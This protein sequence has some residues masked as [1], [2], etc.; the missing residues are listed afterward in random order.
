MT[1]APISTHVLDL[2][3]GEPARG[4][5]VRLE[6]AADGGGWRTVAHSRTDADGR[7]RGWVPADAWAAGDY[8]LVFATEAY[9]GPPAFFPEVVVGFRVTDPDVHHH[10]PL[11]LNRHGYTTYRGS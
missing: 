6:R 9:L 11:L 7:L 1:S 3:R 5:A 4:V 8:R 10:V 2:E